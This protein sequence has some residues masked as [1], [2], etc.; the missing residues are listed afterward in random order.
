MAH[1]IALLFNPI[2]L[3]VIIVTVS[4]F[5]VRGKYRREQERKRRPM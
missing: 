3:S 5:N 2:I 1:L 4:F